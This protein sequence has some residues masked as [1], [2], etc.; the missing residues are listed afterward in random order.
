[1]AF[2]DITGAVSGSVNLQAA[3]DLKANLASPTFTGT[4][5]LPTGTIAVTQTAADSTTALATTAFV[6][7]ADNLKA[8]LASPTFTGTPTLPTGTIGTTQTAGDST[9]ALATTAF[10]TTADNL[11][12]PLASPV[13]TGDPQ[14]PTPSTGD[15]D[16]SI[17][18]TAFVK[19]QAYLTDA[20]SDS[21]A[22]VRQ[23][24]AWLALVSDIPD[25]AWYDHPPAAWV[26]NVANSGVAAVTSVNCHNLVTS[27]AVANSRASVFTNKDTAFAGYV[28]QFYGNAAFSKY[29]LNWSK[30]L[31]LFS[32]LNDGGSSINANVDYWVAIGLPSG[33][34]F[35]GTFTDKAMGIHINT[36]A[37][38]TAQI[39]IIYHDGST[40]KASSYVSYNTS[41]ANN[42]FA[43]SSWSLFSD[44]TGTIKLFAYSNV[45]NGL[46]LT[47]T[48]GPT[49]VSANN[50]RVN[51]GA[52]IL[53]GATASNNTICMLQ[54]R[55]YYGL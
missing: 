44:G 38:N 47:V 31:A 50:H 3:L 28:G 23:N 6:T 18:T 11:K 54:P 39:R 8:N 1:V 26:T 17:A 29:R 55:V 45:Q 25:F 48:D 46:V 20:P 19:A 24:A 52:S 34:A 51:I 22:Y 13:F 40:Q 27:G 53:T 30:K 36:T 10:V 14:A 5:T 15:N 37:A 9:T 12:A 43:N 21:K 41:Q 42:S 7:T 16:T 4:P 2:S 33:G 49:G 32:A 35:A